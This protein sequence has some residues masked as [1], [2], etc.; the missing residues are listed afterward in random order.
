MKP[1]AAVLAATVLLVALPAGTRAQTGPQ[2][3]PN[4]SGPS[5]AERLQEGAAAIVE[6][7]RLLMDQL[8]SYQPPE[9]LP[10]GDV[11]IRRRPPGQ[12]APDEPNRTPETP[13]SGS[14]KPLP[15]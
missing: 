3:A 8:Q 13:K 1:F 14:D 10:N 5:P 11:I 6:G 2:T 15:L 7:L 9:I 4:D 12:P